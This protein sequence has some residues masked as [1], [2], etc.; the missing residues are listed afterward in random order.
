MIFAAHRT[1]GGVAFFAKCLLKASE[2]K[3]EISLNASASKS[4]RIDRLMLGRSY[5][6][7]RRFRGRREA[8]L[9]ATCTGSLD[10]TQ[11]SITQIS[12]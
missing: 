9:F 8:A 10:S 7:A 4:S 5:F 12:V 3:Y 1:L 2:R 6:D 11:L